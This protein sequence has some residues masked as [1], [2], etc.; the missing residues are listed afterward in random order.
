MKTG[1]SL[2]SL[3]FLSNEYSSKFPQDKVGNNV[4]KNC[5]RKIELGIDVNDTLK[6]LNKY[7]S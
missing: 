4:M 3:E 2:G 6:F 1:S 5:L 7:F